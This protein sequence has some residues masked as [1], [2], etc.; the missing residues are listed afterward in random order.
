MG[1]G[2]PAPQSETECTGVKP[3]QTP[4][5][6]GQRPEQHP[7]VLQLRTNERGLIHVF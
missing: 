4:R 7:L 5:G 6:H 2:V 1:T 3:G